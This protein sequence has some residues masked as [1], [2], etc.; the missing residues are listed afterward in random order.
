MQ[1]GTIKTLSDSKLM[2]VI[3]EISKTMYVDSIRN[4][5]D[6]LAPEFEMLMNETFAQGSISYERVEVING[7]E[8]HKIQSALMDKNKNQNLSVIYWIEKYSGKL[9]LMAE[10]Q[11]NSYNVY[12]FRA[13]GKA[14]HYHEYSIYLPKKEI[15]NF[16]GYIVIDNR[17]IK[18]QF[19]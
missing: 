15:D 14:P 10:R 18:E 7:K 1:L 4:V 12:W 5:S 16:Y 2:V 19:K 6:S 13:I 9:Y 11:N 17:F 3:D 8:C